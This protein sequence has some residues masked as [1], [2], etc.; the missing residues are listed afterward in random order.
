MHFK[1]EDKSRFA[2]TSIHKIFVVD[3]SKATMM[4][5]NNNNESKLSANIIEH[6]YPW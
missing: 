3:E 1:S 5:Y 6:K 4:L 2:K